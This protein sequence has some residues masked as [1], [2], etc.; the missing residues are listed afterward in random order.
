MVPDI[1]DLPALVLP[2]GPLHVVGV[3]HRDAHARDIISRGLDTNRLK[4][5]DL[6]LPPH[7][8]TLYNL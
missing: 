8:I 3:H 7:D 6:K 4:T 2:D 1:D 5:M